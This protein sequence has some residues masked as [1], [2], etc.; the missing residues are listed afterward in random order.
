MRRLRLITA[1]VFVLIAAPVIFLGGSSLER[2]RQEERAELT[3]FCTALLERIDREF[4]SLLLAEE[5]RRV[6]DFMPEN[7][8]FEDATWGIVGR[9]EFSPQGAM[10]LSVRQGTTEE[11]QHAW[12]AALRTGQM[13]TP[14]PRS[15]KD[16]TALPRTQDLESKYFATEPKSPD[17]PRSQQSNILRK[18]TL[19]ATRQA[20]GKLMAED[21]KT[22]RTLLETTTVVEVEPFQAA[23]LD[24][25][26]V[27]LSRQVQRRGQL[28]RQGIL[29]DTRELL[30]HVLERAYNDQPIAT[31]ASVELAVTDGTSIQT[32]ITAGEKA[33]AVFSL[34][35]SMQRPFHFIQAQVQGLHL[36]SSPARFH[37][38]LALAG[39][40]V[41]MC[42]G[43]AA[44]LRGAWLV[45]REAR[46]RAGFVSSVTHELKTPLANIRL[47]VEMLE[48]GMAPN[49]ERERGYYATI[50]AETDRLSRLIT[51][52]LE[53]S[54]LE[55]RT[56]KLTPEVADPAP[57]LR[58][59]R[60]ILA[61]QL[62]QT[63][64]VLHLHTE[65]CLL[66]YDEEALLQILLN[67]VENSIKFGRSASRR[68]IT[69]RALQQDKTVLLEVEDTGPGIPVGEQGRIFADFYRCGNELTRTTTGTGIGLALARRFT[70]AM[71]GT[72]SVRNNPEHGCTFRLTF[73]AHRGHAG[74]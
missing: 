20:P 68:E 73:P 45:E 39:L 44:L 66:A 51:N 26:T 69:L 32:R 34:E 71:G 63:D 7:A 43:F 29:L 6:L 38:L 48:Q 58:R 52:I 27:L 12:R 24:Q 65:P 2:L 5:Q 67:L 54:R 15:P 19:R 55:S 37:L 53:F 61:P 60:D 56:R 31:Y 9:V 1:L 59:V 64:F 40:A 30:R 33:T 4:E 17:F 23:V 25:D 41:A 14:A 28:L 72:L 21:K 49:P 35:R 8:I 3:F 74:R 11:R 22:E 13:Q 16:Q 62:T 47:Y 36:P 18:E 50:F 46:R 70:L 57:V 10:R 42:G